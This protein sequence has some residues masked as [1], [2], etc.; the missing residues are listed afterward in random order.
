MISD[1]L[2]LVFTKSSCAPIL[3]WPHTETL[4]DRLECTLNAREPILRRQLLSAHRIDPNKILPGE[5]V[6]TLD[7]SESWSS[8]W[9]LPKGTRGVGAVISNGLGMI[10]WEGL[11]PYMSPKSIDKPL[12]EVANRPGSPKFLA[13]YIDNMPLGEY[14]Y[15][16]A[17]GSEIIGQ[18]T[19]HWERRMTVTMNNHSRIYGDICR[20]INACYL[21]YDEG[22]EKDITER[23]L[24]PPGPDGLKPG[25]KIQISD[26]TMVR[27]FAFDVSKVTRCHQESC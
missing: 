16:G 18:D 6:F 5:R 21:Y 3:Q 2:S 14:D 12:Q 27:C 13:G 22:V 23:L 10:L 15:K 1:R 19:G 17:T 20:E 9:N 8:A 24:Q 25:S 4:L 26:G 11:L 7:W